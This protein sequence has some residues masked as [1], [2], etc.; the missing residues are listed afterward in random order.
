[1]AKVPY[2]VETLPKISIAWVGC[3]NVTDRRQTDGRWHIANMNLSS[4]SLK[5]MFIFIFNYLPKN[6]V[7]PWEPHLAVIG[8]ESVRGYT[9]NSLTR[10]QCISVVVFTAPQ[11]HRHWTEGICSMVQFSVLPCGAGTSLFPP[12]VHL[13]HHLLPFLLF[14]FFHWLYLFSSFVHPFPFYQN[15]PRV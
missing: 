4:R 5:T 12:L 13:L 7:L 14:P 11:H 3:T 6:T 9:T 8:L 1:M 2:G 15:S 10:G